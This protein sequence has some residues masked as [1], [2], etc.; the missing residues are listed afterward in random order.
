MLVGGWLCIAQT[1]GQWAP[2]MNAVG[3]FEVHAPA[4]CHQHQRICSINHITDGGNNAIFSGQDLGLKA[5]CFKTFGLGSSR[6][7]F[8]ASSPRRCDS[9][10]QRHIELASKFHR[11]GCL[12]LRG[13]AGKYFVSYLASK[14]RLSFEA[15][16]PPPPYKE[17]ARCR[18]EKLTLL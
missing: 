14:F 12:S 10:R 8:L 17:K 5:T 13:F 2:W 6:N 4:C 9:S 1:P 7:H 11:H 3:G 16:P 15:S 18:R